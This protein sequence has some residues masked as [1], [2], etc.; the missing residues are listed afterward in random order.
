MKP[1]DASQ[2]NVRN[3]CLQILN[4]LEEQD[5]YVNILLDNELS[6]YSFTPQDATLLT[7]LVYGIL[8][9]KG[10]LDWYIQQFLDKKRKLPIGLQNILR[11]GAY[12]SLYLTQIPDYAIVNECVN[13]AV[14][15]KFPHHRSFVNG[16]LRNILRKRM[17]EKPFPIEA[18]P[19]KRLSIIH[20][21]PEWMVQLFLKEYGEST[22]AK[23]LEANNLIP[24][25]TIRINTLKTTSTEFKQRLKSE[26]I[27]FQASLILP[28]ALTLLHTSKIRSLPG[29]LEG[30]FYVQD[31]ASQLIGYAVA[32]QPGDTVLDLCSAPGGKSFVMAQ[33]MQNQGTIYAVDINASRLNVLTENA[34]RLGI[35]IIRPIVSD[36]TK[37]MGFAG[38][39]TVDA[40]LIDAPCSGLGVLRRKIDA[41][42]NKEA[43]QLDSL[44]A[45][46]QTLLEQGKN[47]VKPGGVLVYSTCT[48]NPGENHTIVQNF[49][50]SNPDFHL[51]SLVTIFPPEAHPF[52][53]EK[54]SMQTFSH[55]DG[56][57]GMFACRMRRKG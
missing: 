20:S 56:M 48:I 14:K 37:A 30:L 1:Q 44:Y 24:P 6:R 53:S 49:L 55:R 51:E 52:V 32:P 45:I 3:H 47:Y 36:S 8:R 18:N 41:R 38:I 21:H 15:N 23:I 7:E 17:L 10:Y 22:T 12:Q 29:Y 35:H 4:R 27:E 43:S 31:T 34:Q 40:V 9:W 54:G 50:A 42:W 19:V 25:L 28:D 13:L 39:K 33:L 16:V 46:Q 2:P 26:D 11:M 5:S 57:D